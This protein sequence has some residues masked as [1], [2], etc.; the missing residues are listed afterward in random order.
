MIFFFD[1]RQLLCIDSFETIEDLQVLFTDLEEF[2]IYVNYQ[3][4]LRNPFNISVFWNA[5]KSNFF[6]LR[7]NFYKVIWMD[8]C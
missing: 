6:L 2:Q 4:D 5:N 8:V 1:P 7:Q 3:N